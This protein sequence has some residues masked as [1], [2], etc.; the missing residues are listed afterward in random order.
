MAPRPRR[1]MEVERE[2]AWQ[3]SLPG[4]EKVSLGRR[5]KMQPAEEKEAEHDGVAASGAEDSERVRR[6][7]AVGGTGRGI[8]AEKTQKRMGQCKGVHGKEVE[9]AEDAPANGEQGRR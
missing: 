6:G 2:R 5:Q 3:G 9:K 7:A 8:S 1:G 4:Q